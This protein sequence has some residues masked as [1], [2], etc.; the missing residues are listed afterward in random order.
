M[1]L[2][3]RLAGLRPGKLLARFLSALSKGGNAPF[4][5]AFHVDP[6]DVRRFAERRRAQYLAALL[7]RKRD[8]AATDEPDRVGDPTFSELRPER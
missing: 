5:R 4:E 3:T 1:R 8:K 6:A 7:K 2:M